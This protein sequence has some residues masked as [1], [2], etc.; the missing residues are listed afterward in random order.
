MSDIPYTDQ[1]IEDIARVAHAATQAHKKPDEAVVSWEDGKEISIEAVKLALRFPYVIPAWAHE[2]WVAKEKDA[3]KTHPYHMPYTD[4]PIHIQA[5]NRLFYN[6][7]DS[8]KNRYKVDS[9]L[10][11]P[12]SRLG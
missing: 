4:L 11:E 10:S 7:I 9:T 2:N 1:Q 12:Q 5:R 6:I 8:L 3:G